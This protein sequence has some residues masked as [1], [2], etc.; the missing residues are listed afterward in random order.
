MQEVGM[1]MMMIMQPSSSSSPS[2]PSSSSSSSLPPL[3]SSYH[4]AI[5]RWLDDQILQWR[6]AL[7]E[8]S[9]SKLNL[10]FWFEMGFYVEK[11]L[12]LRPLASHQQNQQKIFQLN[13]NFFP[14][15]NIIWPTLNLYSGKGQGKTLRTLVLFSTLFQKLC[16]CKTLG[17]FVLYVQSTL[18]TLLQN[19]GYLCSQQHIV[20]KTL[21]QN[22][23]YLCSVQQCVTVPKILNDTDTDTFFRYQIFSIPIP[24]LFSVPNFSDT[25]SETFSVSN[26]FRYHQK[27]DKFPVPGLPGT[28]TSH[29]E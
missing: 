16:C 5:A 27:Y 11:E 17:T 26:F 19:I 21:L 2:A 28:G 9:L 6:K 23:G 25:G 29:S 15:V 10:Q 20:S 18:K 8:S 4:C 14:P 24:V 7:T 3:S 1:M 22:T 12:V 13:Q